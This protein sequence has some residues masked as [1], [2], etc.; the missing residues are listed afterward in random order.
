[1]AVNIDIDTHTADLVAPTLTKIQEQVPAADADYARAGALGV[2][3]NFLLDP[4]WRIV[5]ADFAAPTAKDA[6]VSV[7][8]LAG[9]EDRAESLATALS[10]DVAL[11]Y[12]A[13]LCTGFARLN[14][15]VARITGPFE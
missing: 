2:G 13:A 12:S 1:M 6:T 7:T 5:A 3:L 15:S 8:P 4:V 10:V 11:V 9:D 14:S